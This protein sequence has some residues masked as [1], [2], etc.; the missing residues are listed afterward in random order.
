MKVRCQM[1]TKAGMVAQYDG[2]IDVRCHDLAEWN[3][4]FHAAVK[5]LQRTAFPDYNA[6]MWKLTG[7]ERID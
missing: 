7:Y 5:E 6:S 4:V 1:Q 3:E 2:Y